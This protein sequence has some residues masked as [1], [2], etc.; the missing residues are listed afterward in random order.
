MSKIIVRFTEI[1]KEWTQERLRGM[2]PGD[3][4]MGD[5]FGWWY[6]V[7]DTRC[8]FVSYGW[9]SLMKMVREH[10][11]SNGIAIPED[12][13]RTM[14]EE[15]CANT[16]SVV[17]AENNPHQT[18]M[19]RMWD[20]GSRF[21]RT[22]KQMVTRGESLVPQEEAERRAAI[23]AGCPL[24]DDGLQNCST[25]GAKGFIAEMTGYT[26]GKSTSQDAALKTC[27]VCGCVNRL[28]VWFPVDCM[29]YTDLRK[30]WPEHCWMRKS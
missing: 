10:M 19:Q 12:L 25:C 6:R 23:C 30:M 7:A 3:T 22:I 18:K 16:G 2:F 13:G 15:Y 21:F 1:P 11:G 26:I 24:N 8:V 28:K 20:Q 17:C 4:V 14:M 27:G 5:P 9:N 29:D